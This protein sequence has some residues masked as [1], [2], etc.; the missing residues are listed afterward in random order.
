[1]KIQALFL[2][3]FI[4]AT[5]FASVGEVQL[6]HPQSQQVFK[7][8]MWDDSLDGYGTINLPTPKPAQPKPVALTEEQKD[9]VEALVNSPEG[10]Q[11]AT[12]PMGICVRI[13]APISLCTEGDR[14]RI[15]GQFNAWMILAVA[16]PKEISWDDCLK[17]GRVPAM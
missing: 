4:S 12:M 10:Q 11:M 14:Q 5:A 1:M 16:C 15:T 17:W 3:L 8:S 2:S 6:Y 13:G 7:F 9:Q